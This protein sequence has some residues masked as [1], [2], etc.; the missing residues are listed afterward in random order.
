MNGLMV[1]ADGRMFYLAQ[2]ASTNLYKLADG[3]AG[4]VNNDD[5]Y[6]GEDFNSEP[7]WPFNPIDPEYT[8]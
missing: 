1:T 4:A 7:D 5:Y 8:Y 3:A 2:R 6:G